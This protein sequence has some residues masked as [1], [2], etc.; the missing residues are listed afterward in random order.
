MPVEDQIA[1]LVPTRCSDPNGSHSMACDGVRAAR[2]CFGPRGGMNG[3]QRPRKA[4]A[5]FRVCARHSHS[6]D[7]HA[8]GWMRA[9]REPVACGPERAAPREE[10]KTRPGRKRQSRANRGPHAPS[11]V[12]RGSVNLQTCEMY[13]SKIEARLPGPHRRGS[14]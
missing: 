11:N 8:G 6:S 14:E 9:S 10:R 2:G 7:E 1:V 5:P 3:K 4:F 13:V 12:K